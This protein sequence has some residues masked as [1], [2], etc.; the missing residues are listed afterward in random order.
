MALKVLINKIEH[1]AL[2][3]DFQKEYK[4]EG[5]QWKL[6]VIPVGKLDLQDVTGLN[7]SLQN[8]RRERLDFKKKVESYGEITPEQAVS[9]KK[10]A[11]ELGGMSLDEKTKTAVSQREQVLVAA[12]KTEMSNL[13]E[14]VTASESQLQISLVDSRLRSALTPELTDSPDLLMPHILPRIRMDRTEAGQYVPVILD[15]AGEIAAS[16]GQG[17]PMTLEGLVEEFRV[18]DKFAPLWKGSG[19]VGTGQEKGGTPDAGGTGDKVVNLT[20][21]QMEEGKFKS[22]EDVAEGDVRFK[23]D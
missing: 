6:E 19:S 5:D 12:H 10:I 1:E 16:D 21:T 17:T 3:E 8:V 18:N 15:A 22:L 14:R 2:S 7:N 11:D 20:R 4:V 13:T 23:E 9:H